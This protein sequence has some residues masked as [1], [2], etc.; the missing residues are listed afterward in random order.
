MNRAEAFY[1]AV[2]PYFRNLNKRVLV[3]FCAG[4]GKA[5]AEF[6]EDKNIEKIIFVDIKEPNKFKKNTSG[7]KTPFESYYGGIENFNLPKSALVIA[8]HSCGILTDKILEK[9]VLFYCPVAVMPC[10]YNQNMKKYS[11]QRSP[12]GRKLIYESEKDYYDAFRLEFLKENNYNAVIKT[13][14][15]KITPM[16]NII[17]G[18]PKSP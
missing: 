18:I 12:D 14:D 7:L 5:G 16:N 6:D 15:K 11:L 17:I 13:I 9:A 1:D 3:D 2:Y 4:D 8:V 10:C